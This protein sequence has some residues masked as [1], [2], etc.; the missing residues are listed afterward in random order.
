[1]HICLAMYVVYVQQGSIPKVAFAFRVAQIANSSK[2]TNASKWISWKKGKKT[3]K[4]SEL[5]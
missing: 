2:G 1:M 4:R 3:Q 5:W